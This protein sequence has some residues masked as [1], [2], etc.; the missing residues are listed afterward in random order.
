MIVREIFVI[1]LVSGLSLVIAH[2]YQSLDV[3]TWT[4]SEFNE[5]FNRAI[6]HVHEQH[7]QRICADNLRLQITADVLTTGR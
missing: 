6:E 4:R 5:R 3:K 1:A 7:N 2:G